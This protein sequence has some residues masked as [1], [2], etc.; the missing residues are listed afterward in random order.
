M[1][2]QS[3]GRYARKAITAPQYFFEIDVT[4][5]ESIDYFIST[6]TRSS[7]PERLSSCLSSEVS[8]RRTSML[9]RNLFRNIAHTSTG[10]SAQWTFIAMRSLSPCTSRQNHNHNKISLI[11]TLVASGAPSARPTTYGRH[12][13]IVVD[14][15]LIAS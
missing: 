3:G 10:A 8:G 7:K 5:A 9:P 11:A 12:R 13:R 15:Q 14:A 4:I 1:M 6:R 2:A